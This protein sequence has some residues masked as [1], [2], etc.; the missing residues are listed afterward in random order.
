LKRGLRNWKTLKLSIESRIET[1]SLNSPSF[2]EV[3]CLAAEIRA[4]INAAHCEED[5]PALKR[6]IKIEIPRVLVESRDRIRPVISMPLVHDL[7]VHR[8]RFG[9]EQVKPDWTDGR[10]DLAGSQRRSEFLKARH[11]NLEFHQ[12]AISALERG[13]KAREWSEEE[14]LRAIKMF[15]KEHGQPPRQSDFRSSNGL[16][17][18]ST[19]WRKLG[20]IDIWFSKE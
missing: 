9:A 11:L 19:V 13:R 17:S 5:L 4:M 18:Y 14:I 6:L 7:G 2:D 12:R 8:L 10:A 20:S 15:T 16:P 1:K 3:K